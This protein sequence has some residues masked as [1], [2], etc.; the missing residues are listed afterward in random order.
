MIDYKKGSQPARAGLHNR[1]LRII[2]NQTLPLAKRI[3]RLSQ[4][5]L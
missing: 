3:S 2:A 1:A 4:I 5:I